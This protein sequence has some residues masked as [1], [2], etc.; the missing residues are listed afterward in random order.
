MIRLDTDMYLLCSLFNINSNKISNEYS[1]MSVEEIM[2]A[3]AAQGNA[4][5]AQF[6]REI[7]SDPQKLIELFKLTDPNNRFAILNNLSEKDLNDILPLLEKEDLTMGLKFFTK[8]KILKL[9]E[10]LPKE[11][12]VK[13]TFQMFQP[14]KIV[15]LMPE[16]QLNKFLEDFKLDKSKLMKFIPSMKP[17]ILAQ[18]LEATTG[19]PIKG[20]KNVGLDGKASFN[21]DELIAQLSGLSDDRF[22][23]SM[24]NIPPENKRDFVFKLAQDDP[25]LFELFDADAYTNII[26][27]REKADVIK[28]SSVISSESLVKMIEE[29]PQDLTA[30]VVTQIDPDKFADILIK[31][32][33]DIMKQVIAM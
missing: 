30:V 21:K 15:Q 19:E 4:A 26:G 24:I 22:K 8:D 13:F 20:S 23:E 1:G 11:E 28:A 12:L 33:K 31:E 25:K 29:L 9:S 32:Y 2:E 18:M 14:E 7:L 6:D 3:E 17:E 5:A 27:R 10:E 16:D